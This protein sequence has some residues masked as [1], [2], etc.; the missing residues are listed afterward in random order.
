MTNFFVL[1]NFE[2]K[3]DKIIS[4]IN[5]NSKYQYKFKFAQQFV[6]LATISQL[7]PLQVILNANIA[8]FVIFVHY[9]KSRQ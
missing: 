9:G 1:L 3:L 5:F 4:S 2:N 7:F 6:Q 8:I